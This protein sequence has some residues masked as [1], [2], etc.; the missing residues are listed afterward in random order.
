M[1]AAQTQER[2]RL[3]VPRATL[4]GR[5]GVALLG[6]ALF[7]GLFAAA[8]PIV[9]GVMAILGALAVLRTVTFFT[10]VS[11][12]A[13]NLTTAMGL[14]LAIDYTLLMISRYREELAEGNSREQA[15]ATTMATAGRTV[16][17]S[18]VIV[19]LSMAVMVL[20]PMN[21]LRSFAYAGVATVAF[22]AVA[23]I[24]AP[25]AP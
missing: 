13:L 14:A 2:A 4:G 6:C 19:A 3:A 18:A 24:A 16:L 25:I 1:T 5:C 15:I 11:I 9:V 23:A 7:G 20:F 17:F 22:A 10:E 8:L 12:F 21:F